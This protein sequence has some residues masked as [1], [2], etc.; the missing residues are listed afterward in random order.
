MSELGAL[1]D[2]LKDVATGKQDHDTVNRIRIARAKID[3]IRYAET[4]EEATE[5]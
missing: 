4:E 5:E 3:A 2:E 1:Y